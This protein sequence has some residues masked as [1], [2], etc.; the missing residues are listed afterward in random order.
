[1]ARHRFTREHLAGAWLAF[2]RG[3]C[4]SFSSVQQGRSG[5]YQPCLVI[6][7]FAYELHQHLYRAYQEPLLLGRGTLQ[8]SDQLNV[9]GFIRE[10]FSQLTEVYGCCWVLFSFFLPVCC[11]C[12][13]LFICFSSFYSEAKNMFLILL[14]RLENV[15]KYNYL[16]S[17]P[18]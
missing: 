7:C 11:S 9:L 4:C 3:H 10:I 8:H 5:S 12:Y 17:S 13:Q 14:L 1:M 15:L 18:Y 6:H 2:P 16:D